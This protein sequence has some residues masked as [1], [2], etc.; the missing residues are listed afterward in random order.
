ME[1][2]TVRDINLRDKT[3]LVRVDYNVPLADG[4]VADDSRLRA[5]L[6]TLQLMRDQGAKIVL[7]SHLGRPKGMA[8][9]ELRLAPIAARL[10]DLLGIP[11]QTIRDCVGAEAAT[12]VRNMLPGDVLLLENVRFH[13][14][15][16]QNDPTFAKSLAAL[17]DVYVNDAFG[18]AHRAHA[19]TAGIGAFLPCVAGLLMEKEVSTLSRLL[20]APE[21]P[22]VALIGGAK[23]STKIGVLTHLL[24]QLDVL[25]AGGGIANTL[26][27]AQ[28]IG[29][30]ESL[31]EDEQLPVASTFLANAADSGVRV[32]VPTDAVV[33]IHGD[34]GGHSKIVDI[35]AVPPETMI[36]DVGPQTVAVIESVLVSARTVLWNG[37]LGLFEE[38]RFA[39][40]TRALAHALTKSSA[41]TIVGGGETVAAIELFGATN[42]ITHVS[43]GGGATLEFLEGRTL[44][45]VA[46]LDDA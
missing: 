11:V 42:S 10:S 44:P 4:T 18:A 14:E 31:V 17:A 12:A 8:S 32:L 2:R 39:G 9:D 6:P 43:T 36:G 23:I 16:E 34:P 38:E 7:V 46:A 1:K 24:A 37:P 29:V 28:G 5:T 30:G 21:Q 41:V 25:V 27:K 26:L 19:S 20:E 35:R 15:E 33:G 3:V 40:S 13:A 45:G 22:F